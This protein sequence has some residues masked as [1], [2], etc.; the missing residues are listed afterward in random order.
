MFLLDGP[1]IFGFLVTAAAEYVFFFV[2]DGVMNDAW[3]SNETGFLI[4]KKM[5][6]VNSLESGLNLVILLVLFFVLFIG[7]AVKEFFY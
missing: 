3:P 5:S 6:N 7:R 2:L 1:P 4:R